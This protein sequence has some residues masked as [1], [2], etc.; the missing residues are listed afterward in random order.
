MGPMVTAGRLH[1]SGDDGGKL[2]SLLGEQR[3][4]GA[5]IVTVDTPL[6]PTPVR[7]D[8]GVPATASRGATGRPRHPTSCPWAPVRERPVQH[9][10]RL[11]DEASEHSSGQVAEERRSRT[12]R[13][14]GHGGNPALRIT[15]SA[16]GT[17]RTTRSS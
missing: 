2:G 6:V 17:H 12:E 8:Q 3:A 9:R 15:A 5:A 4:H 7:S 10:R 16:A 13:A 14:P 11:C 1:V